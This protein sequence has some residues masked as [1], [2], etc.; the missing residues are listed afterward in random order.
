MVR[1]IKDAGF[2]FVVVDLDG[3]RGG[4][5]STGTTDRLYLIEPARESGQ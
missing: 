1:A 5:Q 2:R 3:Y 4:G